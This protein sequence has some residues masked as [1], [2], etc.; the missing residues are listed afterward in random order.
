MPENQNK[1]P[2]PMLQL[3]PDLDPVYVNLVRVSHSPAEMTIDFARML[4]GQLEGK[5]LSRILMS[6]IGAKLFLRALTENLARYE[7]AFGEIPIPR[8]SSLANDLFRSIHPT[9]DK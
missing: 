2:Q 9:E 4:P 8:D 6:P 5:V 7:A 3:P 1:P